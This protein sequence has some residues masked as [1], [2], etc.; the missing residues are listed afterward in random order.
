MSDEIKNG[1]TAEAPVKKNRRGITNETKAARQLQFHDKD[2]VQ[3]GPAAGLFIGHLE[4]VNVN[5]AT[6]KEGTS[7]AGLKLPYL[8]FHFASNHTN[9][10]EKRHY[11][12]SLF[13]IESNI[14]TI[15]GGT[16]E[17]RVNSLFAFIKHV[18]DVLYLRGRE[19][20]KEEQSLLTLPFEDFNEKEDGS[21]EFIALEPQTVLDGYGVLFTNIVAMM[22]GTINLKEGETPKCCYKDAAGKYVTLW[23]KL[24]RHKK[25]KKGWVN[26]GQNGEL[27]FDN[28]I[29][30]G[31]IE[32]FKGQGTLPTILRIDTYK[33]SI[34]P[35]DLKKEPNLNVNGMNNMMG[36][37]VMASGMPMGIPTDNTAFMAAG[38][39]DM[40]F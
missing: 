13:P 4:E 2:A 28:F 27:A 5:W 19:L 32:L 23:M 3:Q 29:G 38:D 21:Y 6:A 20:T 24:L 39:G 33:E 40:P 1:A 17:W 15:P 10:G 7:F 22:N 26:V 14:A 12:H 35:K 37:A 9:E 34:T 36:G 11:Y 31:C 8:T 18:L 25:A 16:D 30:S